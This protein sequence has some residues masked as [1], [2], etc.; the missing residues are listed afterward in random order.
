MTGR[1]LAFMTPNS[2]LEY[3][4]QYIIC[5]QCPVC[6]NSCSYSHECEGVVNLLP[7]LLALVVACGKVL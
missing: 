6:L 4:R 2:T 5:L 1:V 7:G 3:V